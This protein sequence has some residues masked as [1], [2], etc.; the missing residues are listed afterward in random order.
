MNNSFAARITSLRKESGISQKEAAKKLGVSQS[1]L[2]HYEKGIRECGLDFICTAA[3]FYGVTC[4]YL[5]GRSNSKI[6]FDN[7]TVTS[8]E[9]HDDTEFSAIT[10]YRMAARMIDS[11][12]YGGKNESK[13]IM[14]LFACGLHKVL[15][16]AVESGRIPKS[17]VNNEKIINNMGYKYAINALEDSIYEYC[18]NNPR[19]MPANIDE[20]IPICIKTIERIVQEQLDCMIKDF[21]EKIKYS[22]DEETA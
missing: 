8:Q 21:K 1:L 16:N 17:W 6:G 9:I 11:M 5:L 3:D 20:E 19:E 13:G 10:L 7:D 18:K 22:E 15:L 2:S 4:D 12:N 14:F